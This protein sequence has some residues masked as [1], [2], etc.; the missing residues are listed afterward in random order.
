MEWDWH[1]AAEIM[2]ALLA[3]LVITIKITLLSFVVAVI[4]GLLIALAKSSTQPYINRPVTLIA[5]GIRRTPLLVQLYFLF[6]VLPDFGV[7]LS[8]FVAGVIALGIH[9][10][11]Y[12]SETFRAGIESVP[13]GQWEAA[14]ACNLSQFQ[15]W[16]EI[17]LPQAIPPMIPPLGNYLISLFKETPILSVITVMDLMGMALLE[18]NTSY[19]YLEPIT[20]VAV[21]FL[22]LSLVSAQLIKFVDIRLR[23]GVA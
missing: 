15:V 17:I 5:E 21:G 12:I 11:T 2:P 23:S 20:M 6:Y 19:R 7:V 1:F 18:A 16:R 10:S 13:A 9:T 3:G 14:K 4:V 8:P 22:L